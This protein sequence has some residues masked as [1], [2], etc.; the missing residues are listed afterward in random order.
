MAATLA[1]LK[2]DSIGYI[3]LVREIETGLVKIPAFQRD[4]VWELKDVVDLLDS[5]YR[6]YP[7]GSFLSWGETDECPNSLCDIGN[8]DLPPL[9]SLVLE[10]K[11]STTM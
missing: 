1:I 8:M 6:G 11:T 4:F 7:I 3:D 2:P 10:L 9:V 5:I